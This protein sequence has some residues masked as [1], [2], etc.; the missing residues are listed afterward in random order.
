MFRRRFLSVLLELHNKCN[1]KCRMCHFSRDFKN[2]PGVTMPLELFKKIAGEVFSK[3]SHLIMSCSTD[4]LVIPT[5][6]IYLQAMKKYRVPMITI[7]TNG[8]GLNKAI[9]TAMFETGVTNVNISIDGATKETYEKIRGDANYEK[10][11]TNISLLGD[12]K[13]QAARSIPCLQ[14]NYTLMRSNL[15]EF[16]EFLRLSKK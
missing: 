4:P 1:L 15:C 7:A 5:F 2:I 11:I 3:A 12:M 9:V 8:T 6:P 14:F 13:T 16:P 10:V